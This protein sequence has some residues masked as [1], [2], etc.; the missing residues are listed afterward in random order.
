M[1][2]MSSSDRWLSF[3]SGIRASGVSASPTPDSSEAFSL[4]VAD[5]APRVLLRSMI[6]VHS[7]NLG[8]ESFSISNPNFI[9]SV[10]SQSHRSCATRPFKSDGQY[11]FRESE[12]QEFQHLHSRFLPKCFHPKSND[13]CRMSIRINSHRSLQSFSIHFRSPRHSGPIFMPTLHADPS[14]TPKSKVCGNHQCR[15]VAPLSMTT[16]GIHLALTHGTHFKHV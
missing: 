6:V 9:W 3:T 8:F 12:L 14:R 5:H 11:L 16:R 10:F 2:R 1:R 4:E 7:E 13:R 15:H